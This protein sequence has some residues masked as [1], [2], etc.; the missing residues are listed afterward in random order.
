MADLDLIVLQAGQVVVTESSS[1]SGITEWPAGYLFGLVVAVADIIE[2]AAVGQTILFDPTK[3]TS[4]FKISVTQY[5]IVAEDNIS[6]TE[7]PL[8]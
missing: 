3:A 2:N 7:Q 8:L 5:W 1:I 4:D 6:L